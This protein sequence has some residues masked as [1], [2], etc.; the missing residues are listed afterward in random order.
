MKK[1]KYTIECY[2][3]TYVTLEWNGKFIFCLDNT[4]MKAEE[5]IYEI[6]KRTGMNFQD[7]PIKGSK[8]DF[9]GLSFFYGGW[10]RDFWKEFPNKNDIDA[11]M[12][13]KSGLSWQLP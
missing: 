2:C 5:M 13:L 3:Y 1:D 11:Y 4:F 10:K 8:D 7:I 6:E 9:Q 12:K